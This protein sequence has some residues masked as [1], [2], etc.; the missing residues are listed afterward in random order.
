MLNVLK[1]TQIPTWLNHNNK[2]DLVNIN[3]ALSFLESCQYI[4]YAAYFIIKEI[5]REIR[6]KISIWSDLQEL[7]DVV[8][9]A[10]EDDRDEVEPD[11]P[12]ARHS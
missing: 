12:P 2:A 7:G 1:T 3:T 10:E 4:L 8:E 6:I 5:V 11:P 9:K